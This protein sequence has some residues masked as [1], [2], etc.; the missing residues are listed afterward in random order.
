MSEVGKYGKEIQAP[1]AR[2]VRKID[3]VPPRPTPRK[4]AKVLQRF[5]F[6]AEYRH[7]FFSE[8]WST[9]LRWFKTASARDYALL[10]AI[11][12][13]DEKMISYERMTGKK[14]AFSRI[15]NWQKV[16]R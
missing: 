6:S 9:H 5:G 14:G 13:D 8:R 16:S 12:A 11:R 4:T 10:R 15:R 1:R 2:D 7:W 3:P